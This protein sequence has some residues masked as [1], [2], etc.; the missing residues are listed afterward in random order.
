MERFMNILI[1]FLIRHTW[2]HGD[3][4]RLM[5]RQL[6]ATEAHMYIADVERARKEGCGYKEIE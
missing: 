2:L 1:Q 4:I 6:T 5:L 3:T